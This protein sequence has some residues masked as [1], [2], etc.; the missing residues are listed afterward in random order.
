VEI[1][2]LTIQE[3]GGLAM[4]MFNSRGIVVRDVRIKGLLFGQ[5]VQ[6]VRIEQCTI[7]DSETTG[8][9]FADS[10][11]TLEGNLIHRND[12]GI[13]VA[14]KSR[15][16]LE[17][18]VITQNLFEGVVVTDRSQAELIHNTIVKNGGGV[19]LLEMAQGTIMGNIVGLN[20]VGFLI[21]PSSVPQ[22][23]YNAVSNIEFDYVHAGSPNTP[24]P[25]L[26]T[27]TDV[28]ADPGFVDAAHGDFRLRADSPLLRVGRFAYLGA[29][30]PL[31]ALR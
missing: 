11:V 20:K 10:H 2:E 18:N 1:R 24:A 4:G 21:A 26:R 14:G 30:P 31:D 29:L 17:R 22:L 12:H 5:Q 13:T 28:A 7:R 16:R 3:H 8:A 15:V 19:A 9:Q 23:S 25:D 27:A 6:D